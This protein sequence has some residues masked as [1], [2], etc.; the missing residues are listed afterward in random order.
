M[1]CTIRWMFDCSRVPG[2]DGCD[3]SVSHAKVGDTGISGHVVVM[4]QGRFWKVDIARDGKLI[5]T[6]ELE[7][8]VQPT[9]TKGACC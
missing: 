2:I 9:F 4:R 5:G 7:R 3:Y 6:S 8:C 1:N